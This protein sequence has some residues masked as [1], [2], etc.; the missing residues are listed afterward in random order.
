VTVNRIRRLSCVLD[1]DIVIDFL[2]QRN[3]ARLLLADWA[4]RGLL[5]ISTLTHLEVYQGMKRG[6][7]DATNRFLDGLVSLAVDISIARRAG[8]ILGELRPKG[9]TIG[10]GDAIIAATALE[11]QVPVLTNNIS[12]CV[13][14]G[15]KIIRGLS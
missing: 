15:L 11:H 8:K 6:E 12:H 5:A 7:E 13:Q 4:G 3:Y 2:R 14:P 10:M 9:I 1:T